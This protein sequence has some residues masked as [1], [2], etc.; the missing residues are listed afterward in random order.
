MLAQITLRH[1]DSIRV[2]SEKIKNQVERLGVRA[3]ISVLPVFV[4]IEKYRAVHA[5]PHAQKTILWNGRFEAEKDPLRAIAVLED[6][7]KNGVDAKLMMIGE[8]SMR[9]LLQEKAATLPVEILPWQHEMAP[10]LESADVV[11]S[12][13]PQESWGASIVEALAAGVAAVS[14]DVG[15]AREAGAI[16]ATPKDMAQKV[17]EVLE[18]RT[19]GILQISLPTASQ[20]AMQW[21]QTL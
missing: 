17:T 16:I 20:W 7:H 3:K 13:S 4:D 19:R 9:G 5:K 8:G 15:V 6:V 14:F 10:H 1:A 2:V 12:T 18:K 11:L 21:K